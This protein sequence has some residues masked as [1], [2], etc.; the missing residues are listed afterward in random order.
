MKIEAHLLHWQEKDIMPYVIKHYKSFCDEIIIH[1][2]HS[3]DGS[4]EMAK[5][6]GC[7]V[8]P[9]GSDFFDDGINRD[10]K[11]ECWKGSKADL[12][13]VADFDE[14]LLAGYHDSIPQMVSENEYLILSQYP[15]TKATIFKTIGWQIMSEDW[16]AHDITEITNGY[17][18]PNYAKAIVFNPQKITEINYGPGAHECDPK[19]DIVWSDA[20]L[21]VL[22]YKHIGGVQRTIDRYKVLQKRLSKSNRKNG[23]GIHYNRSPAS[24]RQEWA[25]RMAKSKPLI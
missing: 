11:N 9:F 17:N 23:W 22:H 3:K 25:E 5:E 20:S 15:R 12:V 18:F 19:G 2:N 7:T 6:L 16:P 21:Y 10:L 24:I 13:V 8:I 1:D 14:L 4:A